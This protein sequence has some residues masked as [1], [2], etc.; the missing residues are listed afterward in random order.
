MVLAICAA[1]ARAARMSVTLGAQL[2]ED[3]LGGLRS[4]AEL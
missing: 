4:F 3:A 1:K 2:G